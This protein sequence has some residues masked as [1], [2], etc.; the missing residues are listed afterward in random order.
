[1]IRFD[2]LGYGCCFSYV[3]SL[4]LCFGLDSVCGCDVI[5]ILLLY[6]RFAVFRWFRVGWIDCLCAFGLPSNCF[7]GLLYLVAL[8]DLLQVLC[9]LF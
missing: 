1:M 5:L 8:M 3:T 4:L 7:V 9:L 2:C 6:G